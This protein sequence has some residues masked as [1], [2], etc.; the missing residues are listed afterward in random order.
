MEAN[1]LYAERKP[2]EEPWKGKERREKKN[3]NKEKVEHCEGSGYKLPEF[4]PWLY[5]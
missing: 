1:G 2:V 3:K 5:F 4:K